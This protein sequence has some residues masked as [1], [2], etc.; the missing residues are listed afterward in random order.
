MYSHSYTLFMCE[1]A[2]NVCM[3]A[4]DV[5]DRCQCDGSVWARAT[6]IAVSSTAI[7]AAAKAARELF[8]FQ[9]VSF[10]Q[11]ISFVT[12]SFNSECIHISFSSL[13]LCVEQ[14][15]NRDSIVRLFCFCFSCDLTKRTKIHRHIRIKLIIKWFSNKI[16]I[17]IQ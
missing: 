6:T 15:E 9:S 4:R 11:K 8:Y 1:T 14:L 17:F 2:S 16:R 5:R 10:V 3:S 7:S 12:S 13:L